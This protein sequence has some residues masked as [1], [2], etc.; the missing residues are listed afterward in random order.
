MMQII[1]FLV[2]N[3]GD[4]QFVGVKWEHNHGVVFACQYHP[5]ARPFALHNV[6]DI[7][8]ILRFVREQSPE[9][10]SIK[11]ALTPDGTLFVRSLATLGEES[12]EMEDYVSPPEEG[13]IVE[14]PQVQLD[15]ILCNFSLKLQKAKAQRSLLYN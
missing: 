3:A 15:Q 13:E 2:A 8:N 12:Y 1:N 14:P 9:V 6:G 10:K 7:D 4:V 11:F 5:G